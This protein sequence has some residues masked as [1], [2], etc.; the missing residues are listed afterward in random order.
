MRPPQRTAPDPTTPTR[1]RPNVLLWLL[2][3]VLVLAGAGLM[4]LGLL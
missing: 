2:G 4:V 3:A 1:H